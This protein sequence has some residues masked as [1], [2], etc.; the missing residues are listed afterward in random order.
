[1]KISNKMQNVIWFVVGYIAGIMTII[2]MWLWATHG[3]SM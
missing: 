3:W 1:M 2:G